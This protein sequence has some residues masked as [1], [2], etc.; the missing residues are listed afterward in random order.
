MGLAWG[1]VADWKSNV[2]PPTT[3]GDEEKMR[4]LN[5]AKCKGAKVSMRYV[6]EW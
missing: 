5:G 3:K 6:T 2:P 4:E 1:S